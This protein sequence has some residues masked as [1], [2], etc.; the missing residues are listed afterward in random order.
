MISVSFDT[1][2][3]AYAFDV[4]DK[5]EW[6]RKTITW[7]HSELLVT[8]AFYRQKKKIA[9]RGMGWSK[10]RGSYKTNEIHEKYRD[11]KS[12]YAWSLIEKGTRARM[13]RCD[14]TFPASLLRYSEEVTKGMGVVRSYHRYIASL[15][16][17]PPQELSKGTER[18]ANS[19]AWDQ[20]GRDRTQQV[21]SRMHDTATSSVCTCVYYVCVRSKKDEK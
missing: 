15:L 19:R 11:M 2:L 16:Q 20:G 14:T 8:R 12:I 4:E 13:R 18:E 21:A 5:K 6:E 10:L 7:V 17:L 1:I 3:C 9:N